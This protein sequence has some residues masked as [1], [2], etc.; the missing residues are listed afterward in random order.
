M[1]PFLLA[2]IHTALG[3]AYADQGSP[4]AA[5][6]EYQIAIKTYRQLREPHAKLGEALL[7]QVMEAAKGGDMRAAEIVLQR[8]WPVRKGRPISME[9][10]VITT[11]A[12]VVTALGAVADAVT[13]GS[14]TT[15]EGAAVAAILEVKRKAIDTVQL[16]A[17]VKALEQERK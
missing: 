15:E 2:H 3:D 6:E 1:A 17:R 14:I 13:S 12:D 10:P 4:T 11:A 7:K 16:E 9:L 5:N 8:I